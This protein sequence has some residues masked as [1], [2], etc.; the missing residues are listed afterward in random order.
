ME[1]ILEYIKREKSERQNHINLSE[2]CLER[3][4]NSTNFRGLLAQYLNTSIPS[5]SKICLC[6]ACNNGKC[7]NPNHL[8]WGTAKENSFDMIQA[9]NFKNGWQ[10]TVAKYGEDFALNHIRKLQKTACRLGGAA[11]AG[12]SKKKKLL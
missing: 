4:G 2:P 7:S 11:T 3:G 1:L 9:G 10:S 5:G 12:I 8:Y 6:H